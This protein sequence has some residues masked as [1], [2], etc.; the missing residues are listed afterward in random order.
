MLNALTSVPV[1]GLVYGGAQTSETP[2][3]GTPD[4]WAEFLM[5]PGAAGAAAILGL[6]FA[7]FRF[8][9]EKSRATSLEAVEESRRKEE[10]WW[11]QYH[12]VRERLAQMPQDGVVRVLEALG[13][14][15]PNPL[16]AA[17]IKVESEQYARAE[18]PTPEGGGDDE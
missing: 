11:A 3:L 7:V 15:A 18:Q 17:L 2:S 10:A 8:A 1:V 13:G 4:W 12:S 5:S 6:V 16:A 9:D 14:G